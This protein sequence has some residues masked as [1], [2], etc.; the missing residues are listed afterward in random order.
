MQ[1]KFWPQHYGVRELLMESQSQERNSAI[2]LKL[3]PINTWSAL[4]L[5]YTT[6][7]FGQMASDG[8]CSILN[9]IGQIIYRFGII[10]FLVYWPRWKGTIF[11][12]T[13]F[14]ELIRHI[15]CLTFPSL[16]REREEWGQEARSMTD[17]PYINNILDSKKTSNNVKICGGMMNI[18]IQWKWIFWSIQ[19]YVG[20]IYN[21]KLSIQK[22]KS[23]KLFNSMTRLKFL[24]FLLQTAKDVIWNKCVPNL[25]ESEFKLLSLLWS[26]NQDKVFLWAV[27]GSD[28]QLC[29]EDAWYLA[30]DLGMNPSAQKTVL[31]IV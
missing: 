1:E 6:S 31:F 10:K 2:Y 17:N 27:L 16:G 18:L 30:S 21:L 20:F 15:H 4:K 23:A 12:Q 14:F 11:L 29:R 25:V 5:E 13:Q 22:L 24:N 8:D 26:H 19:V 28:R 7:H 9:F 3:P